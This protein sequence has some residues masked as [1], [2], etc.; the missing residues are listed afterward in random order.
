MSNTGPSS[1]PPEPTT[2]RFDGYRCTRP[3]T[4]R[5]FPF[6]LSLSFFIFFFHC[7]SRCPTRPYL[8]PTL[9]LLVLYFVPD[10]RT[11]QVYIHAPL[12]PWSPL[13][14]ITTQKENNRPVKKEIEPG[15]CCGRYLGQPENPPISRGRDRYSISADENSKRRRR[16]RR[17]LVHFTQ[18]SSLSFSFFLFYSFLSSVD[19]LPAP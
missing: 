8:M 18:S 10:I 3:K 14:L 9:P 1:R 17:R 13:G 2:T 16:R 19:Q 15:R 5:H 4:V 12:P 6:S 11:H 7:L